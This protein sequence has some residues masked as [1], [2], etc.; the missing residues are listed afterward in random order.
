MISELLSAIH[1]V[2]AGVDW[3]GVAAFLQQQQV[4]GIFFLL[5]VFSGAVSWQYICAVGLGKCH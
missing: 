2:D 4:L 3:N 5:L 1:G